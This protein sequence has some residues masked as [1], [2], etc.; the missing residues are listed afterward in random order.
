MVIFH[1]YVSLPEDSIHGVETPTFTSLG[2]TT[3]RI[4]HEIMREEVLTTE[5]TREDDFGASQNGNP[6]EQWR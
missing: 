2:G 5:F 6:Q 3:K 4:S 1:S